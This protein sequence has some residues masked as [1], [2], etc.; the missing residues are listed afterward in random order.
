ML[1]GLPCPSR[2][3][4]QRSRIEMDLASMIY[5]KRFI[6]NCDQTWW[7]HLRADSS[8]QGGRDFFIS[9]FDLCKFDASL[10]CDPFSWTETNVTKLLETGKMKLVTRLLPL[11]IIGC[12]AASAVHKGRQ[13]LRALSLD[14][15]DL[16]VSIGRTM[17]MM[18]DF[19]AEAGQG[20]WGRCHC[21]EA[22]WSLLQDCGPS[23]NMMQKV[24]P[25]VGFS[26]MRF[27]LPMVITPFIT[28]LV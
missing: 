17:T 24:W 15:Q 2:Q 1:Q 16:R 25:W 13:L 9:E 28:H 7:I 12:R 6:L 10:S 27:Q 8:P 26:V 18:F 3:A 20:C 14:S 19:G 21:H 22:V 4:L 23:K 11:S 5:S